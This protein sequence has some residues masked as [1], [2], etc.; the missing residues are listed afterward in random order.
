MAFVNDVNSLLH[1]GL[2]GAGVSW[3]VLALSGRLDRAD[4]AVGLLGSL[5]LVLLASYYDPES[6]TRGCGHPVARWWYFYA[7]VLGY[8]GFRAARRRPGTPSS[9]EHDP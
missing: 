6:G 5:L 4:T 7:S 8:L 3:L 2:L 9:R 1:L